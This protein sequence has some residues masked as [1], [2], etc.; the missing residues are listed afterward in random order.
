MRAKRRFLEL[1]NA[2][3]EVNMRDLIKDIKLRDE[4]DKMREISP[5]IPAEDSIEVNSS[6]L[7]IKEVLEIVIKIYKENIKEV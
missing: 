7:S 4:A 1:Q 3:Q 5:L 2:G 6:N